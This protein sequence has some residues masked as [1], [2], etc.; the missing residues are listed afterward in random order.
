MIFAIVQSENPEIWDNLEQ[1]AITKYLLSL[2]SKFY[3]EQHQKSKKIGG[4]QKKS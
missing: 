1:I 4:K 3:V 2:A